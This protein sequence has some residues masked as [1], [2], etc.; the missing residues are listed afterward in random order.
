MLIFKEAAWLNGEVAIH[1]AETNRGILVQIHLPSES[2][3]FHWFEVT[4]KDGVI[5]DSRSEE[6]IFYR[7]VDAEDAANAWFDT[8]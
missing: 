2:E 7:F 4:N 3:D 5:Y 1:V 8:Y 6:K